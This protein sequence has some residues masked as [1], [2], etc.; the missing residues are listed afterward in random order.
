MKE[1]HYCKDYLL[2]IGELKYRLQKQTD[3]VKR[4]RKKVSKS[5]DSKK[6]GAF[7]KKLLMSIDMVLNNTEIENDP[8]N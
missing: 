7:T 4:I 5:I 8:K 6:H 3:L 1:C 2:V